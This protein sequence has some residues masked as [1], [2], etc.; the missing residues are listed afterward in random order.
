MVAVTG[1]SVGKQAMEALGLPE[2]M[3]VKR[4]VIDIA[5]D[6]IVTATVETIADEGELKKLLYILKESGEWRGDDQDDPDG[7]QEAE[8]KAGQAGG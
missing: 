7:R 4:I 2:S 8:Q 6:E 1:I 3:R 5:V